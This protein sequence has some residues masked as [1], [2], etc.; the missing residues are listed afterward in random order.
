MPDQFIQNYAALATNDQ[1]QV[2]LQ[3]IEAAYDAIQPHNVIDRS[4]QLK[5]QVLHLDQNTFDLSQFNRVY[6][7]GFGKGSAGIAAKI[8]AIL[9]DH[10]TQGWVIDASQTQ[11]KKIEFTLGTHPL[12]SQS[13]LDFTQKVITSLSDLSETDLVIVLS[14]GGGSAMFE[15]PVSLNLE[16]I[17]GV[18][19]A[20]LQSGANISE[21]NAVRK[22]VSRVKG[23]GLAKALY[24]ATIANLLFSDVPGND[25]AVI[26]SGPTV[27]DPST[28]QDALAVLQKYNLADKAGLSESNF[29]ETPKE[30]KY[31]A[32]LHNILILSNRTALAAM[33]KKAAN[34]GYTAEI[35]SDKFQSQAKDAGKALLEATQPNT[36][37][38]AG[39]ETTV[40]ITGEA[41][42]GGRNQ[43]V[44]LGALTHLEPGQ[45]ICSF[46]SDGWD[47][48]PVA[49]AIGDQETIAKS[50]HQ[51]L[52]PQAALDQHSSLAFFTATA[53]T[54]Q[55][56]RLA[57]N[58]AD[59]YIVL[60]GKG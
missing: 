56:G 42:Q 51:H 29:T 55:T 16:G 12:P 9:G 15:Y 35:F 43:E 52:D 40:R 46:A 48:T 18:N 26:A 21:M 20:L 27:K 50:K 2:V 5:G 36:I 8:E 19:K 6:L 3:L 31:F 39:G 44:V 10:L 7:V 59:L 32:N 53:D 13:N 57:S 4:V 34:L 28:I 45:V 54:I 11:L 58:V 33:Q 1:R 41:G 14:C 38:V 23:G 25:L 24:P 30:D 49:G 37:L 47:N 22:H 60:K 17:I